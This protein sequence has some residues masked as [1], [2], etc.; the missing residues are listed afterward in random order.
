VKTTKEY[1]EEGAPG[2]LL[3]GNFR[4]TENLSLFFF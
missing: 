1:Q 2:G 3:G 4:K